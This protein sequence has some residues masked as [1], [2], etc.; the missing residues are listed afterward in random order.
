MTRDDPD[1]APRRALPAA[2]QFAE[3]IV[4]GVVALALVVLAF[5]FLA[6]AL[7]TGAILAVVFLTRLW[8]LR[9]RL[10]RAEEDQYLTTEYEVIDRERP[11]DPRLPPGA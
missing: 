5:F 2:V 4:I 10:R 7:V 8:W 1:T 9:R 6:A 3:R 11:Q